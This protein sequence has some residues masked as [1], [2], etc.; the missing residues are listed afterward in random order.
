MATISAMVP[1]DLEEVV[2][3]VLETKEVKAQDKGEV[4][5]IATKKV[6][7]LR[8]MVDMFGS[9]L[10]GKAIGGGN[11]SHDSITITNVEHVSGL[12]FNLISVGV[13]SCQYVVSSKPSF[14]RASKEPTKV[15]FRKTLLSY[16]WSRESSYRGNFYTL[17]VI[18]DHSNYTWVVFVES[19]DDVLDKFQILC[20]RLENLHDCS[21][22]SIKTN[23]LSKFNKLQFGS[24]C[25]QHGMSYNLL[26]P[27][28]SQSNEIVERTH[29]KLR[30]MSHAMLDEQSI[31][32]SFGVM[33]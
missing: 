27:F 2:E 24:F 13:R 1:I 20:K 30:K 23:H 29:H 15:E 7:S 22:V 31:P 6:T 25:E 12:A 19:K 28:T 33:H 10:K 9:N 16:V 17:I 11:V 26:G 3:M 8:M 21:I 18:D 4:A 5:T 32:K 14:Q